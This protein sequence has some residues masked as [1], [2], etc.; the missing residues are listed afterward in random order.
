MGTRGRAI[1]SMMCCTL[2][3]NLNLIRISTL[4]VIKIEVAD[5]RVQ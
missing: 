3:M 1:A 2:K 5:H 4:W